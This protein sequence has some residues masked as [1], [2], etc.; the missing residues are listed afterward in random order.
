MHGPKIARRKKS[1]PLTSPVLIPPKLPESSQPAQQ[2]SQRRGAAESPNTKRRGGRKQQE[3]Q[4]QRGNRGIRRPGRR[5]LQFQTAQALKRGGREQ[6]RRSRPRADSR[7]AWLQSRQR[8]A[9]RAGGA[10]PKEAC[11]D[12]EKAREDGGENGSEGHQ[13]EADTAGQGSGAR[14]PAAAQQ[15]S[16]NSG[17]V[18]QLLRVEWW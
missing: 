3:K 11:K 7:P 13:E 14:S 8:A 4:Q 10:R 2:S 6:A 12:E 1:G 5:H 18:A 9:A 17:W 15:R 16:R